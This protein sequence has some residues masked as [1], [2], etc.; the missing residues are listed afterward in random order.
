MFNVTKWTRQGLFYMNILHSLVV[1]ELKPHIL[2]N[3]YQFYNQF[4]QQQLAEDT[5][6]HLI[7]KN[8]FLVLI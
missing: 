6:S 1:E 2:E 8:F 5:R 3:Q 7:S 4:F